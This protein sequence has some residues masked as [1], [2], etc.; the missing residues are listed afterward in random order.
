[1]LI[2]CP[3]ILYT[4]KIDFVLQQVKPAEIITSKNLKGKDLTALMDHVQHHVKVLP[5]KLAKVNNTSIMDYSSEQLYRFFKG[6]TGK[7]L[8]DVLDSMDKPD[9]LSW[10]RILVNAACQY[11]ATLVSTK[12]IPL[13]F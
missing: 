5:S 9:N 8:T 12:C 11:C 10:R 1:M 2:L 6:F 3:Y 4:K 7:S 13:I